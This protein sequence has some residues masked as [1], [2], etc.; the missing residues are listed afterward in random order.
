MLKCAE[1]VIDIETELD[2]TT[3]DEVDREELL[4]DAVKR[5]REFLMAHCGQSLKDL[6]EDVEKERVHLDEVSDS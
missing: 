3:G 6:V 5:W 4:K 1:L 2:E